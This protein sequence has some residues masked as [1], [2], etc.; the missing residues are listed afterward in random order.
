MSHA[1]PEGP[2]ARR[3]N[4][5]LAVTTGAAI[6]VGAMAQFGLAG[7]T[8]TLV[9]LAGLVVL[10]LVAAAAS[11]RRAGRSP[12]ESTG[13]KILAFSLFIN[14]L[15]QAARVP[16]ILGHPLPAAAHNA[17]IALQMLGTFLLVGALLAWHLAPRTRF[18][19]IRH[20]LDGVLFA[21]AVFFILWGLVLGP[22]FLGDRFPLIDRLM[23]LGTFLVYD[24]LLGLTVYFGMEEP[25]RFRGP[26][27]WLAAAFLLASLHNFI[28]L[29]Q[30]LSG[31]PIF[32]LPVGPFIFAVPLAQLAAALSPH[33]VDT[34]IAHPGRGR[35]VPLLP[36]LPVFGATFLGVWLLATGGGLGHRFVLVWLALGLVVVLLVRQYFALRDFSSLSQHLETRVAERT[37]ALEKAQAMLL[38]TERMNSIATLGAGLAHDMN[39]LLTAIRNRAELVIMHLDEG[40]LPDRQDLVRVKE[41]TQLAAALSGRL[42][43][44]GRQDPETPGS[45]DLVEELRAIQPLLQAL[46]HRDQTLR[47]DPATGSLPFRGT[48]GMLEQILV[49][50]IC[51]ARDAM[52]SGGTITLRARAAR[53][54][55]AGEGPQLEVEDTGCG[56][57]EDLQDQV[58]QPFFTTKDPGAGTGLGL[59][60]TKSLLEKMGGA[61]SFISVPGAGTL[62]RIRLPHLP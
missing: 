3:W 16:V 39:N 60:S 47:L 15:I 55:E 28:W 53:P 38:R 43:A 2:T 58:F 56:I 22:V 26:M 34:R 24:L 25:S 33:P 19:R 31:A 14:G 41:A 29:L 61:I 32:H 23:W 44:L 8:R 50:L 36:Y 18:H 17:S 5:P 10:I 30:V 20:G 4:T 42:M 54:Q 21:L 45:M 40:R 27:G 48:R 57:P 11:A 7:Q 51:N 49:N 13:W 59:V 37:L 35:L 6:L 52:P 62:F 46:L 12:A 1:P 9:I